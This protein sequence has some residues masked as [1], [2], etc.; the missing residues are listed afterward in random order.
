MA[1]KHN[2]TDILLM[3]MKS[4]IFVWYLGQH[5]KLNTIC[6]DVL[7]RKN[8]TIDLSGKNHELLNMLFVLD[9]IVLISIPLCNSGIVNKKSKKQTLV[10]IIQLK[11]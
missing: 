7:N 11:Y 4:A 6:G 5:F 1:W 3:I 8:I 9:Q 2:S 10:S